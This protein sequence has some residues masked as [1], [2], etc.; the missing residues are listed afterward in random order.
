MKYG[1][2]FLFCLLMLAMACQTPKTENQ[3][4]GEVDAQGE[5]NP[6][7][8]SELAI[9]MRAMH[10]HGKQLR[11]ELEAGKTISP[12][13]QLIQTINEATPTDGMIDDHR[14][15]EGFS[16]HYLSKL[17]SIY[18][19]GVNQKLQFNNMVSSCITCHQEYCHGPIPA[20]R[21]LYLAQ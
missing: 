21:K 3:S 10:D 16:A 7:G 8:D 5:V 9:V 11:A 2:G 19:Q 13:P 6:N 18:L 17:D 15:F 4:N 1:I 12:Y 20:I 14:V